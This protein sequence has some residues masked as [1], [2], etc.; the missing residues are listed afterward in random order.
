MLRMNREEKTLANA[1]KKECANYNTGFKCSGV[2]IGGKL[3]Q[4]VDKAFADKPCVVAKG[5][6]CDYYN[7]CVK[8]VV[9][10]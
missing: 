6:E 8:P 10:F 2:M 3:Q 9:G 7:R 1:V 5:K 4:W